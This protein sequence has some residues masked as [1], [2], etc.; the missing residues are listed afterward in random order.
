MD[1]GEVSDSGPRIVVKRFRRRTGTRLPLADSQDE[2][3]TAAAEDASQ[4]PCVS[5]QDVSVHVRSPQLACPLRP[6]RTYRPA[7]R[8]A[9]SRSSSL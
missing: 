2:C 1:E 5:A 7:G 4:A 3:V 8:L 9:S 6:R